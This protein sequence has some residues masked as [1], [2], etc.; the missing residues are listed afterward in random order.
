MRE[1]LFKAKRICD[2]KWTEGYYLSGLYIR[3]EVD[4]EI[5]T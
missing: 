1:I 4:G 5:N 3:G 2:G